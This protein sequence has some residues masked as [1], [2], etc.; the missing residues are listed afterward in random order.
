[1]TWRV[2]PFD[3]AAE[4]VVAYVG[5]RY[6]PLG[7]VISG[8]IVRGHAGPNS[9]LDV[10]VVHEHGFRLREQRRFAGVPVEVFVNPPR[11]VR[12]YFEE[13]HAEGCPSTAHMFAT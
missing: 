6:A 7:I 5:A 8:S 4:E 9:D 3:R 10:H 11:Q 12:R 13:E 2:P 1:M